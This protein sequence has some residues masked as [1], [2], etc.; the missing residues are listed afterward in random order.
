[1]VILP[2][3]EYKIMK[4]QIIPTIYLKGKNAKSLDK[5]ANEAL[6]EY[7]NGKTESLNSFLKNFQF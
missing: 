6:E 3:K 5:R 2:Q 1:M 4:N 7:S